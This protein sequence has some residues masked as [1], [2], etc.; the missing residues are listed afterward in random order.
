MKMWLAFCKATSGDRSAFEIVGSA[1]RHAES[2][3]VDSIVFELGRVAWKSN[4]DDQ[5]ASCL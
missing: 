1:R 2:V 3:S 4:L 5:I